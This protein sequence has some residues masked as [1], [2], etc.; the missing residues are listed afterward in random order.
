MKHSKSYERDWGLFEG[1]SDRQIIHTEILK[2]T[3]QTKI[4]EGRQII[5]SSN[6]RWCEIDGETF[7]V[8][9]AL[10]DKWVSKG[11]IKLSKRS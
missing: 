9:K 4:D 10:F 11:E 2:Q 7:N 1:K 6:N 5:W 3:I 8:S